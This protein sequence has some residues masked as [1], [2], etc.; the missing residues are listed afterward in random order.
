MPDTIDACSVMSHMPAVFFMSFFQAALGQD[1]QRIAI[2]L[3]PLHAAAL[4]VK[5]LHFWG[6]GRG[7]GEES[8]GARG[9]DGVVRVG[10]SVRFTRLEKAQ[11][12]NDCLA[13]VS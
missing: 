10:S 4:V 8:G 11:E 9:G 5:A 2:V 1:V 7:G 3:P 12:C 6:R 13:T